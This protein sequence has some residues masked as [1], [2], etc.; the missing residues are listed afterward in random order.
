MNCGANLFRGARRAV[1][2][3]IVASVISW[4]IYPGLAPGQS[5]T[6][7]QLRVVVLDSLSTPISEAQ[8]RFVTGSPAAILRKTGS[9][10]IAEF[11]KVACGSRSI[12]AAKEGFQESVTTVQIIAGA[13]LDL[14]LALSPAVVHDSI[15]VQASAAAVEQSSS[16]SRELHTDDVKYL[17]T[18]PATVTDVL[19][20]APGVVKAPEGEIMIDGTGEH[21]SA[22]MVNQTDVTDPATGAFGLTVPVDSVDTVNVLNTPFLPQ[23]GLFTA[24]VVAVETRRGGDKWHAE[25]NDPFPDFRFRSWHMRGLHDATPRGVLSGPLVDHRLYYISSLQYTLAKKPER[26]LPFPFNESKPESLNSFTQLDFIIS[27]TQFLTGTLHWSPQHVNFVNPNY[28]N[29]QSVTPSYAQ[30]T[31][32]TTVAD[33]LGIGGGML[34]SV[35]SIQRFDATVGS[36]GSADMVLTPAGN[37][38]NYFSSQDREAGRTTWRETWS[39]R[40]IERAGLHE[41]KFGTRLAQVS[42]RGLSMARPIEILDTTDVVLRRIDFTGGSWYGRRDLETT[43]FAQ[44]HWILNSR[45]FL[46]FGARIDR[47]AIA[48]STRIAPRTGFAWTPFS[49]GKTVIRGGYGRF[50]DQVPMSVYAFDHF[51]QRIVTDYTIDGSLLGQPVQYANVLSVAPG[52]LLVDNGHVPGSFAP[53]SGTWS[54]QIEQRMSRTFR[55][56]AVY[57]DSHSVGLVTLDPQSSEETSVLSLIGG[58]RSN[59]RQVEVSARLEWKDS[60]QLVLGYTRSRAQGNL[61][62]FSGIV[63][64]FPSPLIRPD[65]FANLAGDLPNRFLAWGRVN[66]PWSLWLLPMIEYRNGLPYASF[67]VLGN[68]VGVPNG[69]KT[70]FRNYLTADARI[71]KDVKVNSKYTL[72]FSVSGF[73][74]TN[75]FNPLAVHANVA[76]PQYGIFFGNYHLRYRADFDVLF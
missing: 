26:T 52:S 46:N 19:P 17:P 34:D 31:Y 15:D 75:H 68:Y 60:Q 36:Q 23:Y 48:Q 5:C 53:R 9:D 57:T 74:L 50:Y 62:D 37:R 70:R 11:D 54:V 14:K 3:S 72:R 40:Q 43:V 64:N 33:H 65:V 35:I 51:P 44:D 27:A 21:R 12:S 73:N 61:N 18:K 49:S 55:L 4:L 24:G 22:F 47:Q 2:G 67:D 8:V 76:D 41:L 29:P 10:G 42:N 38:G 39:T 20:L 59:Y 63:G 6:V 1:P 58:G 66:L 30:H 71:L 32:V 56:R 16:P 7:E 45:L 25:L 13:R 28:F 69:N